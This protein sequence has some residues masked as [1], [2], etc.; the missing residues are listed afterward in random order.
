[1][2]PSSVDVEAGNSVADEKAERLGDRSRNKWVQPAS[3]CQAC[4]G[5]FYWY[6]NRVFFEDDKLEVAARNGRWVLTHLPA[7]PRPPVEP[8]RHYFD[9][10]VGDAV[11]GCDAVT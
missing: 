3:E 5:Q 9:T 2:T 1:V 11:T 6:E 4:R 7:G 8:V 10:K